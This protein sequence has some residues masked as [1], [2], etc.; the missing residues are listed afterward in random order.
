K[1]PVFQSPTVDS[2]EGAVAEISC[3]HSISNVYDFLWYLHFPGFA[4][5]LLI[6]GS[7]PSQQGRYN[8]TYESLSSSLLIFQ[9]SRQMRGF[10]IVL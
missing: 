6:K 3:N 5:R 2:L 4:P 7:K 1:E 9:V 10:T 8:M